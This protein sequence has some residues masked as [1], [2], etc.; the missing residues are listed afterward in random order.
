M[1]DVFKELDR[2]NIFAFLMFPPEEK[3][4]EEEEWAPYIP[5]TP[6]PVLHSFHGKE[7]GKVWLS[8]V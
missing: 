8:M 2:F 4:D 3:A 5:D 1:Y 7:E 6:S